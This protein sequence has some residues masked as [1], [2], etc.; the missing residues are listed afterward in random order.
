MVGELSVE[1]L[2]L[3]SNKNHGKKAS[4]EHNQEIK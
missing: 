2:E 3:Q 4:A 1:I